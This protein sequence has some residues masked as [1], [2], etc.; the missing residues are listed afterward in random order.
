[1]PITSPVDFISGPQHGVDAGEARE[2][3][4]RF[5]NRP[6]LVG[7][8]LEIDACQ[9]LARH[10]A[11][12][13]LGHRQPDHLGHERHRA[14]GARINLQHIDVAVL[15]G[16]LHVHQAADIER[17]RERAGL[18]LKLGDGRLAERMRWQRAG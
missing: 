1:M 13:D 11:G 7:A 6:V 18:P 3:E 15:D 10:D 12:G 5:L 8:G 16:V 14:R 9:A 4:H 17:N 2:R